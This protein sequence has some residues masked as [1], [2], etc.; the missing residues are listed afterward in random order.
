MDRPVNGCCDKRGMDDAQIDKMKTCA[1][2]KKRRMW[3]ACPIKVYLCAGSAHAE[4]ERETDELPE[5]IHKS[6]AR[7]EGNHLS[8]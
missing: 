3:L 4:V 6:C 1:R 7:S 5:Y 8:V 2:E